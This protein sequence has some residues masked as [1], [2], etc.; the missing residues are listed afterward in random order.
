MIEILGSELIKLVIVSIISTIGTIEWL[1]NFIKIPKKIWAFI[2]PIVGFSIAFACA[3]L[4][5]WFSVGMLVLAG[6]QLCY[7]I[8]LSGIEKLLKAAIKK[9]I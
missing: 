4:P 3:T 8:L 1:K 7:D 2:M 5:V 9:A 6:T